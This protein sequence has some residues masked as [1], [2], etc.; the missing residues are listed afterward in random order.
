M[1]W[2]S[3]EIN[4]KIIYLALVSLTACSSLPSNVTTTTKKVP[5]D[6]KKTVF[7]K[8][9]HNLGVMY[10]IYGKK[11]LR[12]MPTSV[13]DNTGASIAS[14]AEIPN[15]VTNMMKSNLNSLG[16]GIT[17]IPY[18]PLLM[19]R[20]GSQG[21]SNWGDKLLPY[22]II[23]G[24]ITEFDRSGFTGGGKEDIDLEVGE[25]GI[26]WGQASKSSLSRIAVDFNLIDFKTFSGVPYMSVSNLIEVD[27]SLGE[28]NTGATLYGFNFGLKGTIKKIQGRHDAV[29]LLLQYSTIQLIGKY[30]NLP[31]WRLLPNTNKD[32][33]VDELLEEEFNQLSSSQKIAKIQ[34][35]LYLHGKNIDVTGKFDSP[36]QKA[37]TEF[38]TE[39]NLNVSPIV[40]AENFIPI[41]YSVP[42][43]K[44]SKKRRIELDNLLGETHYILASLDNSRDVPNNNSRHIESNTSRSISFDKP[45]TLETKSQSEIIPKKSLPLLGK[46]NLNTEKTHYKIGEK[47]VVSFSV[48]TPMFVTV[49]AINTN[50]KKAILFPNPYQ[51]DGY[52]KPSEN[53][54]IPPKNTKGS[55]TISGPVGTDKIYAFASHQ[56]ISPSRLRIKNGE[57]DEVHL[58]TARVDK[59]I[60]SQMK[61]YVKTMLEITVE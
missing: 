29:R 60:P 55:I 54:Q 34:E 59:S 44:K 40:S 26:D 28:R 21:Y 23:D 8:A 22:L 43:T 50:G 27:K 2:Q 30:A 7:N 42:I 61:K 20:L 57:I 13:F 6:L 56:Q 24:G 15:D 37:L 19:S 38:Q 1:R 10:K 32:E 41:Y 31:Y 45:E 52:V 48:D 36:T 4:K 39:N 25:W 18:D 47:L 9:I 58:E 35:F 3:V 33:I 11:E 53:H 14:K 12:I 46:I 5:P 51:P 17:L 49:V 16:G